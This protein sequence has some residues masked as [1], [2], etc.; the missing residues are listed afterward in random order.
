MTRAKIIYLLICLFLVVL[1]F[2]RYGVVLGD[3]ENSELNQ[4]NDSSGDITLI[5]RIVKEPD[6][7]ENSTKLTIKTEQGKY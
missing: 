6:I 2:Y 4:Y 1:I 7:R 3:L 5:G